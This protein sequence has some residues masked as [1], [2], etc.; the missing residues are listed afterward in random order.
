MAEGVGGEG[1]GWG[2]VR[3][4]WIDL[5]IGQL[6]SHR[7]N[8]QRSAESADAATL[9]FGVDPCLLAN[10]W[11]WEIAYVQFLEG[12]RHDRCRA[13]RSLLPQTSN[14]TEISIEFQGPC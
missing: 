7:S 2:T 9:V 6:P 1:E 4:A 8:A 5:L 14:P 11:R 10:Y 12:I 13:A 3:S